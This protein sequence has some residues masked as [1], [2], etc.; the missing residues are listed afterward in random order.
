[1]ERLPT[2]RQLQHLV[3]LA[4]TQHFGRAAE[5]C[6][7]TQSSLSASIRELE[8]TLGRRIV[9]RTRRHVML[10]PLGSHVVAKARDLIL[11][12]KCIVAMV[13]GA[14]KPLSGIIRMGTIPTIAPFLL[15]RTLPPLRAGYPDLRL[16]LKEQKSADLVESVR[17]GT[18]DVALLAFPFPT[19]DLEVRV[20]A[21]DTFWV[22]FPRGHALEARERVPVAALHGKVLLLLEEG[23][24]LRDQAL[25]VCG[26]GTAAPNPDLQGSSLHTL[27]QMADNGLGLTI[28]PKMAIDAGIIR[29]TGLAVRPLEG[30]DV[31]RRI[32]L[33][34]RRESPSARDFIL[35][36]NFL[37][38]ELATPLPPSRQEVN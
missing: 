33:A 13:E 34:W 22:A 23:H 16:Y 17:K 5:A 2:L 38:T 10:T 25:S 32:G 21:E 14:G 37:E 6:A 20:F 9:E 8:T 35:L 27:V 1:M 11:D 24:C 18:L 26:V 30:P 7:I 15:P 12:A 36:A 28:L 19:G 31:A 29:G 4:D 3:A